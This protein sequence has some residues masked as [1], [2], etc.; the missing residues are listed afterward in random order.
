MTRRKTLTPASYAPYRNSS[1]PHLRHWPAPLDM[2]PP[3]GILPVEKNVMARDADSGTGP[4]CRMTPGYTSHDNPFSVQSRNGSRCANIR[5]QAGDMRP[6]ESRIPCE[7]RA[8]LEYIA[9]SLMSIKPIYMRLLV[10]YKYT[11]WRSPSLKGF[12]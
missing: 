2:I 4:G 3:V 10:T 7:M 1:K 11:R 6:S 5:S 8:L 9:V 12:R